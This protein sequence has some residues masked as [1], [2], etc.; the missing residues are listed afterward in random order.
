MSMLHN[1][2]YQQLW[3]IH[4]L[5]FDSSRMPAT[6]GRGRQVD[7][8]ID[9]VPSPYEIIK[10]VFICPVVHLFNLTCSSYM[11]SSKNDSQ[12][13]LNQMILHIKVVLYPLSSKE[14][15][16][17]KIYKKGLINALLSTERHFCLLGSCSRAIFLA[18]LYAFYILPLYIMK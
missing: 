18:I 10:G 2:V 15:F 5:L 6:G 16:F 7:I 11:L 3:S 17:S 14:A 13:F 4:Y 9:S 1:V 8:Y 12:P